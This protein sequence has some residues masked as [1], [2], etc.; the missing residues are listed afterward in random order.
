MVRGFF[1]SSFS[2]WRPFFSCLPF[3]SFRLFS[4]PLFSSPF[5]WPAFF[6][7][8]FP[9]FFFPFFLFYGKL[10]CRKNGLQF[11]LGAGFG[12]LDAAAEHRLLIHTA[13]P[14]NVYLPAAH[15]A[16]ILHYPFHIHTDYPPLNLNNPL[17]QDY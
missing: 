1:I 7:P 3:S 13:A 16:L 12:R 10:S 4:L 2:S 8:F 5:S 6:F 11:L 14:R 17:M 15:L 9:A